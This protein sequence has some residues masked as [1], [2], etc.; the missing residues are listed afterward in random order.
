MRAT[1]DPY[2]NEN[3]ATFKR[4]QQLTFIILPLGILGLFQGIIGEFGLRVSSF[5]LKIFPP[6]IL[7][8]FIVGGFLLFRPK[9]FTLSITAM[10]IGLSFFLILR[11]VGV[12]FF[13][14]DSLKTG[15]ELAEPLYW[16]P[17]IYI[18]SFLIPKVSGGR[19]ISATFTLSFIILMIL[20]LVYIPAPKNWEV[21]QFLFLANLV[22]TIQFVLSMR[23]VRL[24]E[25]YSETKIKLKI[26]DKVAYMDSLTGLPNRL[27]LQEILESTLKV[28]QHTKERLAVLFIDIDRFKLVNDTL[29][30]GA[31][32]TLLE[33]VATRLKTVIRDEDFVARISGD[34][35]VLIIR[36]LDETL[37]AETLARRIS[38]SLSNPFELM[39]QFYKIS[40]SIG[41]SLFPDDAQDANSLIRH[42]DSAMYKIKKHGK[43][44][45]SMYEKSDLGLERRHMLEKDLRIAL[46]NQQFSL[47][48]QP[49]Y[50][51]ETEK[52]VKLE[53]L[54]RWKHPQNGW[55]SPADFIPIAEE[56]G[57]IVPI[58]N[59]VLK[60]ACT[61]ARKWRLNQHAIRMS[62]N[63]SFLQ[64]AH[65]NFL[66]KVI[67]ALNE[68][69]LPGAS[70]ELE[71]TESIVMGQPED[72]KKTLHQ[73]QSL[74]ISIAI[75]DFGTGYSS[76]AYL[77]ELP[78]DTVKIDRSFVHNLQ[79]EG[80]DLIFSKALVE[81]IVNLAK[82]LDLEVVAEGVETHPQR[83]MLK[84][85][86]CH[87]GQ[88]YLFAKP[89]PAEDMTKLFQDRT[90]N[91][92]LARVEVSS[93][94]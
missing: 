90:P 85:L 39:G 64:F 83:Q 65:N 25:S 47:N 29:G 59:W 46:E 41:G 80:Q 72:V 88:G 33:Q 67:D 77:R 28:A 4:W 31:G 54:L 73:L 48:Y 14:P 81:T 11:T 13:A 21:V 34:E 38:E 35:F 76:L 69:N 7:Y 89:M 93:V 86:G 18:F 63:V 55:I 19:V 26:L 32:D 40:V 78:I 45:F 5:D 60:E 57:L 66:S 36:H 51:L 58:G 42:A 9:L 15:Y 43:N 6:M 17:L 8:T 44:G 52:V 37:A 61:Q 71:L 82:H 16:S 56:N 22:N 1:H 91:R 75:D 2:F 68:N 87:I 94:I 92:T 20:S 79:V 27:K 84:E 62:V 74:G 23:L 3:E 53:A 70:L 12:L 49:M 30:H 10:L 24:Q 50:N